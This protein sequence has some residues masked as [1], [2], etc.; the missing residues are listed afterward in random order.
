MN[1][2]KDLKSFD[3]QWAIIRVDADKEEKQEIKHLNTKL[4]IVLEKFSCLFDEWTDNQRMEVIKSL[5]WTAPNAEGFA[6]K[7]AKLIGSK[8]FQNKID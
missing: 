2:N 5:I 6:Q 3:K 8:K 7:V 4:P 1:Q